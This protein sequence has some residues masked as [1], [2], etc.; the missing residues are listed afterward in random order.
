[1]LLNAANENVPDPPEWTSGE[2]SKV[3]DPV[4]EHIHTNVR[5]ECMECL[6]I[7]L[8]NPSNM[9]NAHLK[10]DIAYVCIS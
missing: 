9:S 6:H 1:M 5:M 7:K 4:V 8:N 10:S 3:Q 2:A